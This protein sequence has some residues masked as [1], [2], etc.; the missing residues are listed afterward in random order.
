MA[1]AWTPRSLVWATDLDVLAPDRVLERRDGYT[2][3]RSPGT[4]TFYWG[5][6]LLFDREPGPG[7]GDRWEALFEA[8]FGADPRVRHRSF[9]WDRADGTPGAARAELA[10]RG[11]DIDELYGL[12]TERPL[13]HPRANAD[14]EVRALD[15]RA[16]EELWSAVVEVHVETRGEGHAEDTHREFIRGWFSD[17]RRSSRRAAARG[18]PPSTRPPAPSP[19]AAASSPRTAAAGSRWSRRPPRSAAAAS[20]RGSSSRPPTTPPGTT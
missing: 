1:E 5:N 4:P 19:A 2:V 6:F 20:A 17:R 9:G 10:A 13:P 15:P 11:Y 3:V 18:T 8:E 12:V 16:D 7:D 14:V